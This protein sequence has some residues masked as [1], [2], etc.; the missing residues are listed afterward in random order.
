MAFSSTFICISLLFLSTF[1]TIRT[2]WL[3]VIGLTDMVP[4]DVMWFNTWQDCF[5]R[6]DQTRW[7]SQWRCS[8]LRPLWPPWRSWLARTPAARPRPPQWSWWWPR[9]WR[10][11]RRRS[12]GWC[13]RFPPGCGDYTDASSQSPEAAKQKGRCMSEKFNALLL[14][15]L[16]LKRKFHCD[17]LFFTLIKA[18]VP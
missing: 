15:F 10:G 17:F 1:R 7:R 4:L 6:Q 13:G 5:C 9:P 12:E 16:E 18:F 14:C 3:S 2:I 8:W 11:P